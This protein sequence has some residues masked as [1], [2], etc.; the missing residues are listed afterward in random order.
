[1]LKENIKKIRKSKGITIQELSDISGI[2]IS[3]LSMYES[4]KRVPSI[5]NIKLIASGL[6]VKIDEF[7]DNNL[8][9]DEKYEDSLIIKKQIEH[10]YEEEAI[11]RADGICEL[12]KTFA[13]FITKEGIPYLVIKTIYYEE[14]EK[15]YT[16][17][18]CPNCYAKLTVLDFDG[19]KKFLFDTYIRRK[20]E[21]SKNDMHDKL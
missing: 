10:S 11:N 1:M 9:I 7:Y 4:G 3:S 12:C 21:E 18:V 17:A 8:T 6:N 14:I 19:D 13:P 20:N 15:S 16:F 5:K 2:S